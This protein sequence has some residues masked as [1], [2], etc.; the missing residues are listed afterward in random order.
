MSDAAALDDPTPGLNDGDGDD[1][2][3]N[4]SNRNNRNSTRASRMGVAA[5]PIPEGAEHP[6][7]GESR[8][9]TWRQSLADFRMSEQSNDSTADEIGR[10]QAHAKRHSLLSFRVGHQ[11]TK[12]AKATHL[13][14]DRKK[15]RVDQNHKH[16]VTAHC[17]RDGISH[18]TSS[19]PDY[20]P[21]RAADIT[22]TSFSSSA[23]ASLSLKMK[24]NNN[25]QGTLTI[26][27][28]SQRKEAA[29][30]NTPRGSG[31]MRTDGFEF[32]E[33]APT[34]FLK[35][36]NSW[37]ITQADYM[38][39]LVSEEM[40]LDFQSNSKSG[41]FFFFSDD[42]TFMI[43][44]LTSQEARW[45][46]GCLSRYYHHFMEHPDSLLAKFV[47]MYRVKVASRR[48][49]RR[50][51]HFIV[52]RSTFDTVLPMHKKFD[53]KGSRIGREASPQDQK[54]LFPVLKDLD[55]E[56]SGL[57]FHLGPHR[58]T[59]LQRLET[60]AQFLAG[61]RMMDFSLLVGIFD[62]NQVD[63][64]DGID[65]AT[66]REVPA[67]DRCLHAMDRLD[68]HGVVYF[69]SVIDFLQRYNANKRFE[70]LAKGVTGNNTKEIS[71]VR[72]TFYAKRLVAFIGKFVD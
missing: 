2:V 9:A 65:K 24:T 18:S 34:I 56:K 39:S 55:L 26:E 11:L 48:P 23:K 41:Q 49:R 19:S 70:T 5:M 40:Y 50:R 54:K 29:G 27:G 52:M 63:P 67:Q 12:V 46:K 45:L 8:A 71:S 6:D 61:L 60:D 38:N 10:R 53:L 15:K 16:F 42:K 69:M 64:G 21:N 43:K 51:V 57:R 1:V 58:E 4:N 30:D 68:D 66:I 32:K 35:L 36:R 25:Q 28:D 47:G 7:P 62:I 33:Y 59:F 37:G 14:K 31:N 3:G 72:P 17:I 22:E 20:S 13:F 44:T